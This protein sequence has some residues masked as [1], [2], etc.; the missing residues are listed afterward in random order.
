MPRYF[1][2]FYKTLEL[3][4]AFFETQFKIMEP[5]LNQTFFLKM[6]FYKVIGHPNQD[7]KGSEGGILDLLRA[8]CV[9]YLRQ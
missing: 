9:A 4:A 8:P 6:S 5:K 7:L 1:L 3:N 2:L